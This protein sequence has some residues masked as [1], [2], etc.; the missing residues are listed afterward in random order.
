MTPEE[1]R[2]A[3]IQAHR[4]LNCLQSHSVEDCKFPCKCKHCKQRM[5]VPKHTTSLHKIYNTSFP[6]YPSEN[7]SSTE[8]VAVGAASLPSYNQ[9]A[10]TSVVRKIEAQQTGILTRIS[11]VQISNPCTGKNTLV[12]A[13]HDPGSQVTLISK[14]LLEELDLVPVGK[15]QIT[16]H[17]I[18]SSET[19]ELENVVFNLKSLHNNKH[20]LGLQALVVSPWSDEGY[21]LPHCQDLSEYPQF[22]DVVPYMIPE[23]S[24]VDV[25]IGLDNSALMRV[26]QERTGN[27][28]EPHA[29]ETP[30]G[31]IASGGKFQKGMNCQTHKISVSD[32]IRIKELEQ[33]VREFTKEDEVIQPSVND[34]KAQQLVE[35][36]IRVIDS[37]Y[38][39]PVPLKEDIHKLP[40]N[41]ELAR[42]RANGLRKHMLRQ[43][44]LQ[45]SLVNAIQGLKEN[46]FI[47][48]AEENTDQQTN[49]LPY[50]IT[51]QAK[52]RV[53][54]DGSAKWSGWSINDF[55]YSGPDML[56]ILAHV[57]ARFRIGKYAIMADITKCFFQILLPEHQQ[58]LF[59]I[60]WYDN[61]D[62]LNGKLKPYKFT[63]HVWGVVS[64]P[65]IACR[66]IREITKENPTNASNPTLHAIQHCMYMDDLLVS[67]DT[68]EEAETIATESINL[69]ASR[70][71]QLV[72]WT[73]NQAAKSVL[74]NVDKNK[75]ASSVRTIDLKKDEDPLPQF[76]AVGCIWNVEQDT[77]KVEF[78]F[79]LLDKY[80]RRVMLS[81]ISQQYDPLGYT[82]PFLLKGRLILQQLAVDQLSWDEPVPAKHERAWKDWSQ[83]LLKLK[84]ISIPRWYF[85]NAPQVKVTVE[86]LYELHAF[87]DASMEAY[88]SVI[89]LRRIID[90]HAHAAFVYGK[91]RVILIHQQNWPIARKELVAAVMSA[92][93]MA[94]AAKALGLPHYSRHFWCDSKVVLQWV[95]NPNLRLPKFISRRLELIRRVSSSNDWRYCETESNPADVATRPLAN[96]H[97]ETR[98]KLWI[99]GPQFLH[100]PPDKFNVNSIPL[101]V[102][103]AR[104]E[105]RTTFCKEPKATLTRVIQT[106]LNLYTLKKRLGYLA[107]FVEFVIAKAK[108]LEFHKPRL[109]A[110]YLEKALHSTVLY[111]QRECFGTVFDSLQAESPDSL[112][113]AIKR[114]NAKTLSNSERRHLKDLRSI[115]CLRPAA[116]PDGTLRIEGRL[117]EADLPTDAKHPV[118]L[119]SR[120]P[121]TRLVILNCH[122][123]IAH[124]GIQYTLM[125]T[126]QK[127][128]IIKGLSSVRHYL[129]QCNACNLQKARPVRQL[130]ADLP[131]SRLAAHN[132]PF[133]NTGCDYFG[134]LPY[135]EG[136]SER[137]A[138][139]LLFTCL[140][141]RAI[142]VELVTSLDLSNFIM[143]F[144]RFVDLRGSVSS[145]YSNNGT[146]F[147]AA[148]HVLPE[149]L[150]ADKLQSFFRKKKI[151][152]EFIPPYSPSQGG[153]WESLIKVFKRTLIQVTKFPRTP[154]LVEL[155]TYICNATRI[156]ND[157]PLTPLSDD[158]R[159]YTAISPSSLLTPLNDP[160][161]PL[162]QPHNKDHL[163]RDYRY[164]IS[165]AQQFWE[166]WIRFYLPLLQKRK[167][168]LT[169][170]D[171]LHVGQMVVVGGPG[172]FNKR[173]NYR[174]GRISEVLPQ[175][176]RGKA[177]VRRAKIAVSSCDCNG[178]PVVMYIDR[179]ISKIAPLELE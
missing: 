147:K 136:R 71:F 155:Q 45:L 30:L 26:L 31:W 88:G 160:H 165:L 164:N 121:L 1:K 39:I 68:L 132:K 56:N 135:K 65:Y 66:S 35:D 22:D 119:P 130:M 69:L 126:R 42:R 75:L 48:P 122:Q 16:L 84:E 118:I 24:G 105:L 108:K 49:Y 64:S 55:I 163:R 34:K 18:S 153:A 72:K 145:M 115:R 169:V 156:V 2:N 167:K 41:Y 60:L 25:L 47:I 17:T 116:F 38:Q 177:L 171:N 143:A 33:L 29:I 133:F 159:D 10:S 129:N 151:S 58:N 127:Y 32:N 107:A 146:T 54:Y 117:E 57:L 53:V 81:Q 50:F 90:N 19:S 111:V 87:S 63:R 52:P 144:S 110:I 74:A 40:S 158:P 157:H 28:G 179:D 5:A 152:W 76:K 141:T 14:T 162:G 36:N 102:R 95:T 67:T 175:M 11:A 94:S 15:S 131:A 139:G 21:T 154:T 7:V 178:K 123:E 120:H 176:R 137:K 82:A 112:E 62:I 6:T 93:L 23:R 98:T 85:A 13:Q 37:R 161:T 142:H 20:F 150:E 86:T 104:I 97:F 125:L 128:W 172:D 101:T 27:E 78:G 174:L 83:T 89:Y 166:R 124:A 140:S 4:C 59:R 149:L 134:P 100:L 43:P 96:K 114:L 8:R 77:L 91:S 168:W 79:H 44:D 99:E 9:K 109:N 73:A 70:G 103:D 12:Y 138:W 170:A 148:A 173:G 92:E 3:I 61:D 106:S 51:N 113:D 80:T 46:K